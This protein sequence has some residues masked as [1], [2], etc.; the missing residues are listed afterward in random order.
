MAS[1]ERLATEPRESRHNIPI[2]NVP[3]LLLLVNRGEAWC[4]HLAHQ[5]TIF[6]DLTLG[7]VQKFKSCILNSVSCP[8][9]SVH[10]VVDQES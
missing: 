2:I 9:G 3:T 1:V 10:S 4:Q 7:F 5:S 6:E 8:K